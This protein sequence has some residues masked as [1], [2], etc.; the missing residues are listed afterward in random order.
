MPSSAF[1][2]IKSG[3]SKILAIREAGKSLDDVDVSSTAIDTISYD[4]VTRIL[5]VKFLESQS[6]YSYAM[7]DEGAADSFINAASI[8]KH[9]NR[10]I[11]GNYIYWRIS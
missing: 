2:L 1:N 6:E 10:E 7:V 11:K 5:T 4:Y 9:F 3:L 8:G